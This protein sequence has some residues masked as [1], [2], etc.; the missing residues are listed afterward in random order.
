M[1]AVRPPKR[2]SR[3]GSRQDALFAWLILLPIFVVLTAV[4][5]YPA[6][7]TLA[8]SFFYDNLRTPGVIHFVGL[9]NYLKLLSSPEFH[10]VLGRTVLLVVIVLPLELL[11]ALLG[12]LLLNERFRGRGVLRALLLVP[13]ILP[14]IANG[15]L[16]G[17]ILNGDYG[18]LNGILYQVGIIHTYQYWLTDPNMQ[19]VWVG[20][21]QVWSRYALPMI[22]LLAALQFIDPALYE[23]TQ[24]DG[25]SVWQRFR[26]ITLPHL[27]PAMALALTIEFIGAFQIFDLIWTLTAGGGAGNII[28][29][30]TKTVMV[31]NYEV[32]FRQ[33]DLGLGSALSYLILI[34]SLTVGFFFVL[35]LYNTGVK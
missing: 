32:V 8:T 26:H 23:A 18:A 14:P 29:P 2:T 31:Y 22:V 7:S 17:W 30:F 16:W 10:H 19:M 20:V 15:F 27:R 13:W 3:A 6:L 4:I 34:A 12:A 21:A 24:V 35:R 25:A 33:L 9:G 5:F 1:V 11:L 28:N